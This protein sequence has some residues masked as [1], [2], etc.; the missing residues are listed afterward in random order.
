MRTDYDVLIIGGGMVGA[1]L[2]CALAPHDLRVAVVESVSFGSPAQPSYDDR[3]IALAYGSQRILDTL[4]I[5]S[6]L[7]PSAACAIQRIHISDR[8]HAG[9]TRLEASDVGAA[10][11]GYVVENRALGTALYATLR[12]SRVDLVSP[13]TLDQLEIEDERAIVSVRRDDRAERLT[14][15]LVVAADGAR[16]T[17][18]ML[19]GIASRETDYRQTAVVSNVTP[20]LPHAH[21]AFERFTDTGPL[22]LL[23]MNGNRCAVVWSMRPER[24][25]AALGWS[26]SEFL[27]RLQER[28]GHRLGTFE[29][30]GKRQ[31]YPLKLTE[32]TEAVRPRLAVIGNAAHTLHPVAGQGFNLGLRDVAVLS[33]ILVDAHR[34]SADIGSSVILEDYAAWRRRDTRRV[35]AFTGGMVRLFSNAFPPLAAA[36]SL[37]LLATDLL[38]PVKRALL[39]RTMGLAGRL[40]RLA[41]GLPL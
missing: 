28:F 26:D 5:W 12:A 1:S 4:G 35:I 24:V 37:G 17:A 32:A 7:D 11:L 38:P 19:A 8:G 18:R 16:S 34:A 29:R 33:Q 27:A 10:A 31:A 14:A 15:R 2:A 30:V 25:D 22:A 13:A 41:R 3:T 36:R 40:P 9:I 23:P 6:G 39:Q 21:T 20:T